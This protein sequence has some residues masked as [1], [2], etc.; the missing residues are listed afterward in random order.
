MSPYLN[1]DIKPAGILN[2]NRVA[3]VKGLASK[4]CCDCV[5]EPNVCDIKEELKRI[6][7]IIRALNN[8]KR[9]INDEK[10][11]T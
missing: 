8:T 4:Y 2:V 11:I 1:I 6:P 9:Y 5:W 3:N 10:L 7:R